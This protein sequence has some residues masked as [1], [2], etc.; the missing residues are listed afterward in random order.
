MES[1]CVTIVDEKSGELVN[2]A[3]RRVKNRAKWPIISEAMAVDPWNIKAEKKSTR[4]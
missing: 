3:R 1:K 4:R 2:V